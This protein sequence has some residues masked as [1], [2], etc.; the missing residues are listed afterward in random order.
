ML[1]SF[2][3]RMSAHAHP[4]HV[5]FNAVIFL[6]MLQR[7]RGVYLLRFRPLEQDGAADVSTQRDADW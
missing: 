2:T 7:I 6:V 3:S 4:L 5:C 1:Y